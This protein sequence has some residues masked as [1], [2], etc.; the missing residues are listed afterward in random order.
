MAFAYRA[1][2]IIEIVRARKVPRLTDFLKP[3]EPIPFQNYG[4][5]GR[6]IDLL[7]DLVN[8]PLV[9]LK[10][11]VRAPILD[12]PETY[13]AVLLLSSQRIRGIGW[14]PTSR[15]RFYKQRIPD[16]WHENLMDPHRDLNSADYNR[17]LPLPDLKIVDLTDFFMKAAKH[18]NIDLRLEQELW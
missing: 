6:R 17:H 16:G 1:D 8:G 10:F 14:N 3:G 11:H 18:W 13:E 7:L 2:Q 4:E 12:N 15:W 5:K 9:D